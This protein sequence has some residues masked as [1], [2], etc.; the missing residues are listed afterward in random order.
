MNSMSVLF[1]DSSDVKQICFIGEMEQKA[2]LK[3]VRG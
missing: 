1:D 3:C 2:E